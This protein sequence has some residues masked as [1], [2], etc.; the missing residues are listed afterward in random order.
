VSLTRRHILSA[1]LVPLASKA[2]TALAATPAGENP[3]TDT[4]RDVADFA[5]ITQQWPDGRDPPALIADVTSYIRDKP[6]MSLGATR[7]EGDRM[8]DHWLEH[9]VDLWPHFG[10]FMHLPDGSRV[11]EWYR[12]DAST[13]PAPIVYIGSEGETRIEA[14]TLEAFLASWAL[15]SFDAN[16]ALVAAGKSVSLPSELI[17][18]DDDDVADGRPAF[19]KFLEAKLGN[20]LQD[21][22]QSAPPSAPFEKFFTDWGENARA[23]I[24]AD[25][26]LRAIAQKLDSYVPRGKEPWERVSFQVNAA[27]GRCEISGPDGPKSQLPEEAGILPLVLKAREARA[28][29]SNAVRGLWHTARILLMPDAACHIAADWAAEP[30]FR[31]GS[32]PTASEIGDDLSRFPRSNRWMETWMKNAR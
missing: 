18:G 22:V 23:S 20:P 32:A 16:G 28:Q 26:T 14:P 3:V 8:D 4:Y 19:A 29:G 21:I 27:G 7:L 25:P 11:A 1:L 6:W 10:T 24:A 9:G 12:Q 2:K 31:D 17:R 30:K 15:A 13:G 5:S